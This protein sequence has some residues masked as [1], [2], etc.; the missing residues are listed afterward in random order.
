[1]SSPPARLCQPGAE[2]QRLGE[3]AVTSLPLRGDLTFTAGFNANG[4]MPHYRATRESHATI[5]GD[6]LLLIDSGGQYLDGTTDITRTV[7]IGTPSVEMKD[8]FTRVLQGHIA[9]ATANFPKGTRGS[10]LDSFAR[11]PIWEAGLDY[12]HGTGHAHEPHETPAV[13]TI[14]L[15]ALAIPSIAAG[16]VIGP[17]LFGGYFGNAIV[18]APAHDSALVDAW[19]RVGFGLQFAYAVREPEPAEQSDAP[20]VGG[21]R[22]RARLEGHHLLEPDR[23]DGVDVRRQALDAAFEHGADGAQFHA[24]L[25]VEQDLLEPQQGLLP[26]VTI[27]VI[28]HTGRLEKPDRIVVMQGARGHTRQFRELFYSKHRSVHHWIILWLA[29]D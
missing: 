2:P 16:W 23:I 5:E 27:A 20:A 29:D 8:R 19:F 25:T 3:E 12:A 18:V 1:M 22:V 28:A 21:D 4:A 13:V 14:P 10:Q 7:A 24:H 9:V 17:V 26:V 15:I 6:G 11:R